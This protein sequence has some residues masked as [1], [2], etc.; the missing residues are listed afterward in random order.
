MTINRDTYMHDVLRVCGGTNVFADR[1]RQFPLAAD[2]SGADALPADDPRVAGRDVRYPRLVLAD[3]LAAQPEI[4]L[5]PDEPYRFMETD[6]AEIAALDIPAARNKAIYLVDGSLL[7]WHG[8]R[9]AYAL[10]ELPALFSGDPRTA[11]DNRR[12]ND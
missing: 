9:I 10:R 1:D 7:T 11:A 5:L 12:S 4:V 8:T 2:L 6:R 3:V